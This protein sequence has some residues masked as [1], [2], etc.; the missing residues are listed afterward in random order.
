[1]AGA[2]PPSNVR[3]H[4]RQSWSVTP[5]SGGPS[6]LQPGSSVFESPGGTITGSFT[7]ISVDL[8]WRWSARHSPVHRAI[9]S[10]LRSAGR[11]GEAQRAYHRHETRM[12]DDGWCGNG[13]AVGRSYPVVRKPG[14]NIRSRLQAREPL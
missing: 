6:R 1:V 2:E 14:A 12:A 8:E 3:S 7:S 13:R 4:V 5:S 11:H 10:A 9:V